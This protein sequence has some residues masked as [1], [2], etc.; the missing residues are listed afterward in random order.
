MSRPIYHIISYHII[1]Y[2]SYEYI[3]AAQASVAFGCYLHVVV[4]QGRTCDS[5]SR[6]HSTVSRLLRFIGREPGN[7]VV[8]LSD[9]TVAFSSGAD[10]AL[11]AYSFARDCSV[12]LYRRGGDGP[13]IG[14]LW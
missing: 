2:L 5:V 4:R 9:R 6:D 14:V 10:H 13:G 12:P 7:A 1:S 3:A 8:V 11:A